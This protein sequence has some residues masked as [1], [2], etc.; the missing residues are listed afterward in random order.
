[1]THSAYLMHLKA[2]L[3]F[4]RNLLPYGEPRPDAIGPLAHVLTACRLM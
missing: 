1:M 2:S 3:N 4:S